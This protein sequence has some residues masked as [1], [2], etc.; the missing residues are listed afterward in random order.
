MKNKNWLSLVVRLK[1]SVVPSILYRVIGCGLF[2]LLISL[3]HQLKVPVSQ[4]GLDKVITST[5]LVLGL[6]LVFRTNTAYDRFWE[7]RKCWGTVIISIRNLSRQ[8]WISVQEKQPEDTGEK[9]SVLRLL[10]AFAV[11]MKLH[12]RSEPV[13]SEL[14]E[15]MTSAQFDKL[16]TMSNPPLEIISWIG[17]YLQ[18]QSQRNCLDTYQVTAFNDLLN[19]IVGALSG[20]ERILRTPIPLAYVIHLKQLILIFSLVLPFQVVAQSAWLTGP[21]VA[22][23][24]FTLFGI[25][26]IGIEIENPFGHDPNDLPLDGFC[27]TIRRNIEDL[28]KLEP[29]VGFKE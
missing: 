28:T 24:S 23:V 29:S 26:E 12:L 14:A 19:N 4:P 2:G 16:K 5:A 9:E 7:G 18:Q 11:A 15:L 17:D 6:L 22:L 25:E 27:D 3:L 10:L 1:G 21:M 13:N 20:C 8:I